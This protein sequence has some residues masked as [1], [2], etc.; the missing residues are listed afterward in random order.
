M[1]GA[2]SATSGP[3]FI[4]FAVTALFFAF[5]FGPLVI[6]TVTAFNSSS[7]PRISPWE[8]FTTNWFSVLLGDD[9]LM[10]GLWKSVLI[11]I[12]VVAISVPIGLA[13]ALA[14]TEVGARLRAALYTIFLIPILVPGIVIGISTVV[15]WRS[16]ALATGGGYQSPVFNG[17]FLTVAGQVSFI[18]AYAMLIFLSRLQRFDTTL[19]D[20]A[21]DLGATPGQAF[22][23]ILLPFL[24]PAIF[25]A[26]LL[27]LLA[28]F[29]NYNTTVFTILAENTF[30]T[31]LASKVRF[32]INPS[33]S[34]LAVI[35]IA[36]TL[37]GAVVHEAYQQ[38]REAALT[39]RRT[40]LLRTPGL[41]LATN[42][43]VLGTLLVAIA[44]TAMWFGSRYDSR[45]CE[46]GIM[47]GKRAVQERL[48]EEQRRRIQAP[49]SQAAPAPAAPKTPFGGAFDP[50]ALR[51]AGP[52]ATAPSPPAP[53]KIPMAPA[54]PATPFGGAF[55]PGALRPGSASPP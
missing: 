19:T 5:L 52:P 47:S 32:G 15:F 18:A 2:S 22:R 36:I 43:A 39:G 38:R 35:I 41:R 24:R 9:R 42:P 7:F 14:L 51:P 28:S 40:F 29:E 37:I 6:M 12:G 13:G 3:R 30:T 23:K 50:G 45:A 55:N 49:P 8:C 17:F 21:L 25:S 34:A 44:A 53:G 11:G 26:A 48:L 54:A 33:L 20:A 10:N 16:V 27:A 1:S 4:L 46:Q 31:V